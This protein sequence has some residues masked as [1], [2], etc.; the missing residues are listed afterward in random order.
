MQLLCCEVM[1][2][3]DDQNPN[4]L[5]ICK[6]ISFLINLKEVVVQLLLFLTESFTRRAVDICSHD[7]NHLVP[8]LITAEMLS[9][10]CISFEEC[11]EHFR[12]SVTAHSHHVDT[13]FY[14]ILV[15]QASS[16]ACSLF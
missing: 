13:I 8:L 1:H 2:K 3:T 4:H 6:K 16:I 10:D 12:R 7:S 14:P 15:C 9:K 11:R 5:N